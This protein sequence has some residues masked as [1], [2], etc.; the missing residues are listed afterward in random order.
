MRPDDGAP[1]VSDWPQP[2]QNRLLGGLL[3]PQ[4][5]QRVS[6]LAPQPLQNRAPSGL[7]WPH[8]GHFIV[9]SAA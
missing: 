2:L 4:A 9:G 3:W 8:W 5:A 7:S 6:S 1:D